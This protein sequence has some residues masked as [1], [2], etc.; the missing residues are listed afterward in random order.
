MPPSNENPGSATA[1]VDDVVESEPR[2]DSD[3]ED[4]DE[5]QEIMEDRYMGTYTN[6]EAIHSNAMRHFERMLDAS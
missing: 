3:F 6:I 4:W 1:P 5:Y 2:G